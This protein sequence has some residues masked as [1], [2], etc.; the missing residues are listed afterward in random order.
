MHGYELKKRIDRTLGGRVRINNNTL[1]PALR[2][3]VKAGAV[4]A[5]V[6]RHAGRPPRRVHALTDAGWARLRSMLTEFGPELAASDEEFLTR[7]AFFWLLADGERADVLDARTTALAERDAHLREMRRRVDEVA[8][9]DTIGRHD[10]MWASE[11][12]HFQ[13]EQVANERR[14]V[15]RLVAQLAT[16]TE[17]GVGG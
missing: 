6:Q 5:R 17:S 4:V 16:A 1:Y 13:H 7:V 2:R 9:S 15:R 8:A 11:V 12:L 14:W 10:K 3:F